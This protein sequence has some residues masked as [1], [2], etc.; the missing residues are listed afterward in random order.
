VLKQ[1]NYE[2]PFKRNV[3]EDVDSANDGDER[4]M[5][6]SPERD[7]PLKVAFEEQQPQEGAKQSEAVVN[8]TTPATIL[9]QTPLMV[10]GKSSFYF[11]GTPAYTRTVQDENLK[12]LLMSWYYAGYHTGLYEGRQQAMKELSSTNSKT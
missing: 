11:L 7:I 9:P 8:G 10:G 12:N 2:R 4:D 3:A 6:I 5:S 1:G